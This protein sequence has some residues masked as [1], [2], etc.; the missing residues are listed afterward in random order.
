MYPPFGLR[1]GKKWLEQHTTGFSFFFER[2]QNPVVG[3]LTTFS[4]LP[5]A[6]QDGRAPG[7]VRWKHFWIFE[8]TAECE[9]W[10]TDTSFIFLVSNC[11]PCSSSTIY[12]TVSDFS[13]ERV[14]GSRRPDFSDLMSLSNSCRWY[15]I[16]PVSRLTKGSRPAQSSL[17]CRHLPRKKQNQKILFFLFFFSLGYSTHT[18]RWRLPP[19]A[20]WLVF[21]IILFYCR[22]LKKHL[23]TRE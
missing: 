9:V 7:N 20:F 6:E 23:G 4:L 21:Y 2:G 11:V 17:Y 19:S 8:I 22:T 15:F 12:W 5:Y 1:G 16:R 3:F 14:D 13:F 18:H 10:T